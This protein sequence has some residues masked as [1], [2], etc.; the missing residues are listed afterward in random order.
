MPV[1]WSTP[2]A[3]ARASRYEEASDGIGAKLGPA[4]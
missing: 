3:F 4:P 1:V 2:R